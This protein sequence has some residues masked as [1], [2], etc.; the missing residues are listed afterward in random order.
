MKAKAATM[1]HLPGSFLIS[2][3]IGVLIKF[4]SLVLLRIACLQSLCRMITSATSLK[5]KKGHCITMVYMS[6]L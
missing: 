3:L 2:F 6:F 1:E 5:K 4:P